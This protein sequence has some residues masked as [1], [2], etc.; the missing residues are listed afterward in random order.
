MDRLGIMLSGEEPAP[1]TLQERRRSEE[2][3]DYVGLGLREVDLPLSSYKDIELPSGQSLV[4]I[5]GQVGFDVPPTEPLPSFEDQVRGA[6]KRLRKEMEKAKAQEIV[7]IR[8]FLQSM[9]YYD[10]FNHIY[11][12]EFKDKE[13]PAR[14]AI[15]VNA[16]PF[17]ALVEL[18]AVARKKGGEPQE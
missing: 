7:H 17:G 16:L 1:K 2:N 3:R 6:V 4:F 8:V 13:K 5:S 9:A 12:E 11:A 15:A 14:A 18:D 10:K